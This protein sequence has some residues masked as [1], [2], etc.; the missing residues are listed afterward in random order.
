MDRYTVRFTLK[1]PFAWFL[2]AV[3]STVAWVVPREAVEQYG[4]L[5]RPEACIGTGPWM[6]ERYDPN[7]RLVWV[8]NPDY[9]LPGLP[10]TDGVEA[11]MDT[12]A[13]SRLAR[14]LGGQFDFAPALGAVVRRVDL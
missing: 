1:T 2:D 8:R 5:K 12:D 14:W 4:D 9:F 10:Y 13:S 7:V 11:A 6:L 3:A